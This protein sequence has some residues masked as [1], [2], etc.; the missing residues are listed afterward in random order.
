MIVPLPKV[1]V[2]GMAVGFCRRV[3]EFSSFDCTFSYCYK[4]F[5]QYL[6]ELFTLRTTF[7]L[8]SILA[9]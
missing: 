2:F 8:G 5:G 7:F 1:L 4:F 3:K 9:F 6:T